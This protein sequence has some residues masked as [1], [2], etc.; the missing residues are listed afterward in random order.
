M[1]MKRHQTDNA[2]MAKIAGKNKKYGRC[3]FFCRIMKADRK[4]KRSL[5]NYFKNLDATHII[6]V[7]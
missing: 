6:T 3:Q 1:T 5:A 4:K 7:T 2:N